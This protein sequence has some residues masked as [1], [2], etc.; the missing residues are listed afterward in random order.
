MNATKKMK[1]PHEGHKLIWM[2][3]GEFCL[4]CHGYTEM[5]MD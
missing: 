2:Q 4:T 5:C 1:D 3:D